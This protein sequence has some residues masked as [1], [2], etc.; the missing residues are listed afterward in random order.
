[1]RGA[2]VNIWDEIKSDI[3]GAEAI[4]DWLGE[5]GIPVDNSVSFNRAV[6]CTIGFNGR[7][8]PHNVAP[9]WWENAKGEVANWIRREMAIKAKLNIATP[10]D[11]DLHI[12]DVCKC[13]MTLKVHAPIQHIRA[14]ITPEMLRKFP[15]FCWQ[16]KELSQ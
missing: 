4:S 13:C 6:S 8:C 7:P 2:S 11:E 14:H 9:R 16:K 10:M 1:M 5:G 15:V 3:R 12:C